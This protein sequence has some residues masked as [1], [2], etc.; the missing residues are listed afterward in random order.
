MRIAF[1]ASIVDHILSGLGVYTVNLLKELAKLHTDLV[2]Y[3]S[4]P[5]VCGVDL[6]GMRKIS[7]LV[8]PSHGRKGHLRRLAWIQASLPLRLLADKASLILSPVPEGMLLPPVPQVVVVHDLIPLHFRDSFPRHYH[9]FR[10]ILPAILRRARAI[11]ADSENTRRDLKTF[12]G[13]ESNRIHIVPGGYDQHYYR[14][15]IDPA[16]VKKECGL[17]A[18]LLYVGNL[19]PHK[20]LQ[21]LLQAF[22]LISTKV[23]HQLAIAGKKDPRYLPALEAEARA[24]GLAERVKFLD[25]ISPA[26]LPALYAGAEAAIFP[27]LYEGFGLP[28]LESMACGTPVIASHAASLPEV[29]GEAATLIDPYSVKGMADAIEAVL[30]DS[31]TREDMKRRGVEQAERFSWRRT[32]LK[33]LRVLEAVGG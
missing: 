24:L 28:I 10:Y 1:N 5:E 14:M 3:T 31:E 20:N 29:T 27:S 16:P 23:P 12:Y 19:L 8:R 25:Y 4:C 21:R 18:Y 32:A 9:Y 6:A 11:V 26:H 22:A 33:V 30:R 13:L 17:E 2:V 15:G 7:Q